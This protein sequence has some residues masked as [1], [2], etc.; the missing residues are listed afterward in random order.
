MRVYEACSAFT[1]VVACM[2]AEPPAAAL[3]QRIVDDPHFRSQEAVEPIVTDD[4]GVRRMPPGRHDRMTG[5]GVSRCVPV[6]RVR[7]KRSFV[8]QVFQSAIEQ[9]TVA[10][11]VPTRSG[12]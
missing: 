1:R 10:V 7:V 8:Q 12:R 2:V 3:C 5:T 11:D 9:V 6:V 4:P